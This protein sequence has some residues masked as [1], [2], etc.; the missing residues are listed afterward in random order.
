[1]TKTEAIQAMRFFAHGEWRTI[2]Y[3]LFLLE[4]GVWCSIEEFYH[5]R[6]DKL[7]E[8]GVE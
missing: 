5:F 4:D 3:G 8:N 6:N 7:W 1:M 2:E